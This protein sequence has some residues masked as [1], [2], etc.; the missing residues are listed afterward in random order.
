MFFFSYVDLY[1]W[2]FYDF[3]DSLHVLRLVSPVQILQMENMKVFSAKVEEGREGQDGEPSVG[4]V[5][6][7]LLSK[8]GYPPP[9]PDMST[10]L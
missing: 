7:N 5:Y 8:N 3:W 6:C 4:P 2:F 9:D 10:A 1:T